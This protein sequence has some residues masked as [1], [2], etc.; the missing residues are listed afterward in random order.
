M[1]SRAFTLIELLVVIAII[2]ILAAILF[3]VFA[4][5]KE[6]AKQS[7]TISNGKQVGTAFQIYTADYDDNYPSSLPWRTSATGIEQYW[8]GIYGAS[9]PS[10]SANPTSGYLENED[11]IQWANAIAPYMKNND[12]M[13]LTGGKS[14]A[15]P[16]AATT[17]GAPKQRPA[18][19]M[20]NGL[21][22]HYSQTAIA[23]PSATPLLDIGWGKMQVTG[24]SMTNPTMR[25]DIGTGSCRFNAGS[26]PT[27]ATVGSGA[28]ASQWV[29]F[30]TTEPVWA[31]KTGTILVQTDSS[32]K[33]LTIGRGLASATDPNA[34]RSRIWYANLTATGAFNPTTGGSNSVTCRDTTA[35]P[36]YHC[37]FRPDYDRN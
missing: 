33:F 19:Y 34:A 37:A 36:A 7:S 4:Q 17:A 12:I 9:Y 21:L 11:K 31:F 13:A 26:W 35:A 18:A 24:I 3:P 20:F 28:F 32:T 29:Y 30:D 14:T 16:A 6:A 8:A 1:R 2:A 23:S 25:C 22:H 15:G 5:A 27:S 10:G